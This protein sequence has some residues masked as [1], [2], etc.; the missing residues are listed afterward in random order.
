MA[1]LRGPDGRPLTLEE[2]QVPGAA[3]RIVPA[4]EPVRPAR[5]PRPAPEPAS[6]PEPEPV[7]V[8]R[9][10][11]RYGMRYGAP[12]D[13]GPRDYL[14]R[15][16][17]VEGTNVTTDAELAAAG[18]QT[19]TQVQDAIAAARDTDAEREAFVPARLSDAELRAVFETVLT[20]NGAADQSARINAALAATPAAGSWRKVKLV[21]DFTITSPIVVR[22]KTVLDATQAT[23]NL[24]ATGNML[25]S[26][27]VA[28]SVRAVTDAAI[29]ADTTA[30]TSAT[31][32]FT[33]ADIG[34]SVVV[35]NGLPSSGPL[36]AT[37]T[38]VP[39]ATTATLSTPAKATVT[40]GTATLYDRDSDIAILGG[41]WNRGANGGTFFN[42]HSL[43]LRRVDRLVIRDAHF[44]SSNG[45]FAVALGDVTDYTVNRCTFA[46][47]SDGVH[48]SGPAFRGHISQ[49]SGSTGDDFVA[50][51]GRDYPGYEDVAGDI[52][53]AVVTDVQATSTLNP[54]KLL[55]GFGVVL[56]R[57]A[58][59]DVSAI[60]G[61]PV[62]IG[63][64]DPALYPSDIDD[65]LVDGVRSNGTLG[66]VVLGATLGN[67]TIRNVTMTSAASSV[68]A[69]HVQ[70]G[71]VRNLV[72]DGV[73]YR[74]ASV[75]GAVL[76]ISTTAISVERVKLANVRMAPGATSYALRFT[77]STGACVVTSVM[78]DRITVIG[79]G[80]FVTANIA[81]STATLAN[82]RISNSE[83]TGSSWVI[84]TGTSTDVYLH[85]VTNPSAANGV[86]NA[87]AT[88]NLRIRGSGNQF[89]GA[90]SIAAG[91]IVQS[92]S[93]DLPYSATAGAV[94]TLI[95]EVAAGTGPTVAIVGSDKMGSVTVT[96]GTATTTGNLT[97]V[98]LT[99]VLAASLRNVQITPTS[100]AAVAAGLHVVTKSTNGFRV[101]ATNAPAVSTALTFDYY[102]NP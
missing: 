12:S 73:E 13:P 86:I 69:V 50:F 15:V 29:T 85:G 17:V 89:F 37:I 92:L 59:R 38:A 99:R 55:G 87:R 78:M 100:Q 75:G 21:G 90:L 88:A 31:A 57:F 3:R 102:V 66:V 11:I 42:Q 97:F 44:T 82:L 8:R 18:G 94:P 4:P 63:A 76:A 79:G 25:Q 64:E 74:G 10:G 62:G 54:V 19:L 77:G 72:V 6:V 68:Y 36:C 98:T 30:L 70:A 71:T 56:R 40:A 32:A 2:P 93:P 49:L 34:R 58:I 41:T 101:A 51:T 60:T 83:S 43:R 28:T 5:L 48:V 91:A 67:I 24:G 80:G 96:T 52:T 16:I 45:K 26:R 33:S 47:S 65:V 46:T 7:A 61:T 39:N 95:A 14:G 53:D 22:S 27:S 9:Q 1:E 81:G 23:I 35:L 20:S 84:D